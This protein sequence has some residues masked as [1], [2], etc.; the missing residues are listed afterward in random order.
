MGKVLVVD[1]EVGICKVLEEFLTAKDHDVYTAFDGDTAIEKV[2]AL[3]PQVVLLD[4]SLPGRDG[5]EVLQ[6]IRKIDPAIGV[7][8]V[9]GLMD[10]EQ[11][12]KTFEL[13]AYDYVTKP[14]DFCYLDYVISAKMIDLT[15]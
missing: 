15:G 10:R 3:K 11:A 1:D 9:T 2:K 5:I 14:V 13:G 7:V 8:M 6:A 12:V 4:V